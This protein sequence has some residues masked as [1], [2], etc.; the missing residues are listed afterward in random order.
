MA[1]KCMFTYS[2][3]YSL[4]SD[5]ELYVQKSGTFKLLLI[6]ILLL[7]A[8]FTVKHFVEKSK[9]KQIVQESR[10]LADIARAASELVALWRT[11]DPA[12]LAPYCRDMF[13]P[14]IVY[15]PHYFRCNPDYMKCLLSQRP[16]LGDVEVRWHR[17]VAAKSGRE[18]SLSLKLTRAKHTQIL[19]LGDSCSSIELPKRRY[20][21]KTKSE[22]IRWDNFDRDIFIDRTPVNWR[23]VI[24]WAKV[25]NITL[26]N[27]KTTDIDVSKRHTS[28]QGLNLDEMK[29]YCAYRGKK[30]AS[31]PVFEA[32]SYH[33]RDS[34]VIRPNRVVRTPY[35]W[36]IYRKSIFLYQARKNRWRA[37]YED[38]RKAY[39]AECAGI[40]PIEKMNDLIPTWSGLIDTI[41]GVPE[42]FSNP[43]D[44][45]MNFFPSSAQMPAASPWHELGKYIAWDGLGFSPS[46]FNG[47]K[48]DQDINFPVMPGFRCM[49]ER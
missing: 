38:C 19:T 46:D 49:E 33:P 26:L 41:G 9:T 20:S 1:P 48:D 12:M 5:R 37:N 34:K 13:D 2:V 8:A 23:D 28:A 45:D 40:K 43:Y 16:K 18:W 47:F 31:L 25:Q 30:L 10:E 27:V 14:S 21:F 15:P 4:S 6:A 24:E 29:R 32:A 35:P 11:G 7:G 22:D 3:N 42:V 17:I 39:V 36:S 44:P